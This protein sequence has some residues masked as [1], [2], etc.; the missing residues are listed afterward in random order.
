MNTQAPFTSYLS[1]NVGQVRLSNE[2]RMIAE[3]GYF[4]CLITYVNFD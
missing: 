2:Y 4:C 3:L 1:V